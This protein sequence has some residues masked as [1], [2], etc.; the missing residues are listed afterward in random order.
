MIL[1]PCVF[2]LSFMGS[3]VVLGNHGVP[4]C[5]DRSA[6]IY[7]LL[8]SVFPPLLW[9]RVISEWQKGKRGALV[10]IPLFL[11]I[12]A[13][14]FWVLF[15]FDMKDLNLPLAWVLPFVLVESI[16]GVIFIKVWLA[17]RGKFA[18]QESN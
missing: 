12:T 2:C 6:K 10:A 14:V 3:L 9:Y 16:T 5:L 8:A 11:V 13:T 7:L 4:Q 18:A 17:E 15:F 1:F